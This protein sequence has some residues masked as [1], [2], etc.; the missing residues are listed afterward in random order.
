M[1]AWWQP[2]A[3]GYFKHVSKAMT[4]DAVGEYAP[5]HVTRL[6]KLKRL[7]LPARP[8]GW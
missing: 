6:A 7:T 1:A 3:E 8:S 4:L 5:Q 2:T